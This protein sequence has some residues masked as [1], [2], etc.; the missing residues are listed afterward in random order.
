[1]L[2]GINRAECSVLKSALSLQTRRVRAL[3]KVN[4]RAHTGAGDNCGPYRI[5][6]KFYIHLASVNYHSAMEEEDA[7][8]LAE[9][10]MACG[11]LDSSPPRKNSTRPLQD[12]VPDSGDDGWNTDTEMTGLLQAIESCGILDAGNVSLEENKRPRGRPKK[13][14]IK[15]AAHRELIRQYFHAYMRT[16]SR[17]SYNST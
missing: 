13:K 10:I 9:E 6:P 3:M 8:N 5:I 11:I 15:N 16:L 2:C 1:M 4:F 14:V 17:Q 7:L 12:A